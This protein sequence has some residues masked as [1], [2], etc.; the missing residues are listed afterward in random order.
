MRRRGPAHAGA[1]RCLSACPAPLSGLTISTRSAASPT[2][3]SSA[4]ACARDLRPHFGNR[5]FGCDICQEVCPWNRRLAQRSPLLDGLHARADR[6]APPL[7]E[8][9]APETPYWLDEQAFRQKFRRS[10]LRRAKRSGML[11]NV[12]IALG[13]WGD[14]SALL[15]LR[16]ALHDSAALARGHAAWALGRIVALHGHD[17]AASA[18]ADALERESDEWVRSEIAAALA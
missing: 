4:A 3:P 14:P 1:A 9:F 6:I 11:R 17:G 16:S 8:G 15:A 13:N 7:L 18:L 5:I 12:C 2:G 10:P